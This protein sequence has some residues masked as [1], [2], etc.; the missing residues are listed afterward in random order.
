MEQTFLKL[1]WFFENPEKENFNLECLYKH[2]ENEWLEVALEVVN[3]F[4]RKDTFLIK[5][6]TTYFVT[7][8]D[9]YLNQSQFADFLTEHD[10]PFTRHKLN[11][12]LSRGVF[13]NPD[14]V[15]AGTKYW[16]QQ[17][18]EQYLGTLDKQSSSH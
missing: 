7:E 2:L 5:N 12:Y 6:P 10:V 14:M 16:H 1:A 11:S 4:F 15:A 18:C 3:T 9:I 17:T 13:P 8:K